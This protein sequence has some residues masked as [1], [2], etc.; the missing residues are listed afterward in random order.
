[1]NQEKYDDLLLD[2]FDIS[3]L[4]ALQKDAHATNQQVGEQIHLSA[5]QVSR[6]IQRLETSG[7]IRRYVALLDPAALGLGVRAMSY[8][9]LSR[10]GGDEGLAF[11]REIA[12][13]P[14]VL[15]CY[16]VAGESDYI[17]QIVAADLTVLSDSVL[18]KLM[19]IK[20]VANIR[21]N[22]VL[23]CIKSSTELPL[24]HIGRGDGMARKVR[25]AG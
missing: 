15:D 10:H 5:S 14:E 12:V 19:R 24:G 1:M 17:L 9:T 21:S 13:I 22:I 11:E 4:A 3:L 8:V 7:I 25:I 18:K 2:K 20:G 6:R 16:S 23:N